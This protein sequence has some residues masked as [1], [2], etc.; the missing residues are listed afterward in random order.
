MINKILSIAM[1]CCLAVSASAA[2]P[3]YRSFTD[4]GNATYP[5]FCFM[6][7]DPNSQVRVVSISYSSDTNTASIQFSSGVQ[8]YFQVITNLVTSGITNVVNSTNGLVP[9][10]TLLLQQG[11][12]GYTNKLVS[13]GN[14]GTNNLAW[15]SVATN[16]N[17]IVLGTGGWGVAA[18]QN[19]DIYQMGTQANIF[20]GAQTN[21][22]DG[23]DIY[24]GA[25]GRP[26]IVQ[27]SSCLVTDAFNTISCHYDSQSQ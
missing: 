1:G 8:A 14:T 26:V 5:G 12:N 25:Y 2:L 4:P 3:T 27:F 9:N 24:S 21:W 19:A 16:V 15:F 18:N 7:A 13:W 6:P 17:F 11:G 20:V 10:S 23:D 22:I